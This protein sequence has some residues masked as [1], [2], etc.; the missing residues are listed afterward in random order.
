VDSVE[1]DISTPVVDLSDWPFDQV[2]TADQPVLHHATARYRRES[3]RP[4]GLLAGF[5]SSM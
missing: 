3:I 5:S 2:M 4:D 1:P